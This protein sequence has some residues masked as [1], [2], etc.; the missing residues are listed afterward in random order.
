MVRIVMS[1]TIPSMPDR[2][3]TSESVDPAREMGSRAVH[4]VC[5]RCQREFEQEDMNGKDEGTVIK[6]KISRAPDC[7]YEVP[8]S[9]N[10]EAVSALSQYPET[11]EQREVRE[12][13]ALRVRAAREARLAVQRRRRK[14]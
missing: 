4:A 11:R 12:E 8:W 1:E 14:K 3:T 7:K 9:R 2:E 6:I 13:N 5:P 10:L